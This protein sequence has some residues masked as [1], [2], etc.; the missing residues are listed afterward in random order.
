VV[1]IASEAPARRPRIELALDLGEKLLMSGLFALLCLRT[2]RAIGQGAAPV[3]LIQV[4]AEGL[5]VGLILSRRPARAISLAPADW[6][7]AAGATAGPLLIRPDAG[8]AAIGSPLLAGLFMLAGIALQIHGKLALWRSFGVGPANRGVKTGGPY[9]LVRHPIYLGYLVGQ[10]GYLLLNPTAW[11]LAVCAASL[12]FQ[13]GRIRAEERLLARD[14]A[15]AAYC[16]TT[17]FRL[18]PGLW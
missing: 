13:L 6:A 8:V 14:P 1:S 5:V 11:N 9:R 18:L 4:A 15:F 7:M 2:W 17:R 16:G 3:N 12:A 10:A